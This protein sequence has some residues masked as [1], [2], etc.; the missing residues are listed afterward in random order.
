MIRSS[1]YEGASPVIL[2][3]KHDGILR[4]C[5]NYRR[6]NS[7]AHRDSYQIPRIDDCIDKLGPAKLFTS[8]D[9]NWGFCKFPMKKQHAEKTA[10]TTHDGMYEIV[11][12]PFGLTN[13]PDIFQRALYI[14]LAQFR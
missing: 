11:P 4:F 10:F 8:L 5:V 13:A 3:P 7:L 12:M 2:A 1:S 14:A 9:T 6:L